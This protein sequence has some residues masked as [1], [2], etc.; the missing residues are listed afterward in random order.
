M[1]GAGCAGSSGLHN[2]I[3]TREECEGVC[4]NESRRKQNDA[5]NA[6]INN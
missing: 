3:E 1:C 2:Y 6:L 5:Q 4:N